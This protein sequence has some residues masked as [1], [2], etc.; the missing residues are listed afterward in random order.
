MKVLMKALVAL[1]NDVFRIGAK[2]FG[3][4]AAL[5]VAAGIWRFWVCDDPSVTY[6]STGRCVAILTLFLGLAAI[7]AVTAVLLGRGGR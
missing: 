4:L 1:V 2:V 6:V 3:V 5:S 7:F